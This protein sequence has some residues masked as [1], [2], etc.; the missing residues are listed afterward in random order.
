MKKILL[1]TAIMLASLSSSISFADSDGTDLSQYNQTSSVYQNYLS[2]QSST[3]N[4]L[5]S[6]TAGNSTLSSVASENSAQY[7]FQNQGAIAD[8]V[9]QLQSINPPVGSAEYQELQSLT[10]LQS[11]WSNYTMDSMGGLACP[12]FQNPNPQSVTNP[13]Q[14]YDGY[15]DPFSFCCR[16]PNYY[17]TAEWNRLCPNGRM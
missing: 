9:S 14:Y 12:P 17:E 5:L 13:T 4:S 6:D 2:N 16:T 3:T 15:P 8:R 10:G 1:L 11:S 7:Y